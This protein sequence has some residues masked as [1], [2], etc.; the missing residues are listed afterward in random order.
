M[1]SEVLLKIAG[2]RKRRALFRTQLV[3]CLER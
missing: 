2:A 3:E 1:L